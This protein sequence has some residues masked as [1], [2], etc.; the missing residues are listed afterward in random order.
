ML[1]G[2]FLIPSITT[3]IAPPVQ[4]EKT[5]YELVQ[6]IDSLAIKNTLWCESKWRQFYNNGDIVVGA[7]GEIGI[8]QF[9]PSTWESFNKTRGTNLDINNIEHQLDMIVW[10]FEN[11]LKHHWTCYKLVGKRYTPIFPHGDT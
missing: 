7:A 3:Y 1:I 10:A 11:G 2:I 4:V 6:E 5:T 9:M 8:A